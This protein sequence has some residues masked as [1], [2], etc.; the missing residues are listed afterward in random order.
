MKIWNGANAEKCLNEEGINFLGFLFVNLGMYFRAEHSH[1]LHRYL[2]ARF[3]LSQNVCSELMNN[4][5]ETTIVH[6]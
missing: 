3:L 4:S 6:S 5:E 1:T 2:N